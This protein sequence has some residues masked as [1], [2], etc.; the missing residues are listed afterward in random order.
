M[1]LAMIL[2]DSTVWEG[3]QLELHLQPPAQ[4]PG[5]YS[6][7]THSQSTSNTS[8]NQHNTNTDT[9]HN[10]NTDTNTQ[11]VFS[12]HSSV[13]PNQQRLKCWC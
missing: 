11:S 6:P 7:D 4:P 12:P 10:T 1:I 5:L 13:I 3:G 8:H 2:C 9:K